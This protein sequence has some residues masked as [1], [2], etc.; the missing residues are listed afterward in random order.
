MSINTILEFNKGYTDSYI[1]L[2]LKKEYNGLKVS[3]KSNSNIRDIDNNVLN[4]LLA[5]DKDN[6]H[7][8]TLSELQSAENKNEFF[9]KLRQAMENFDSNPNKDYRNNLFEI[10]L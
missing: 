3:T 9:K 4:D 6:N 7:C 5:A 10:Y 8:L 1:I 2:P